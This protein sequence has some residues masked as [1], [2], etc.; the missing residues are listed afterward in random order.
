MS[1]HAA[2]DMR[3]IFFGTPEF[4]VA[5]LA[6]MVEAG[7]AP[8]LVITR[9]A[10]PVGRGHKVRQTPVADWA[11]NNGLEVRRPEKVNRVSFRRD[12]ASLAP[13][14]AVVVAYGLIFGRRLLDLP[15]F[16]CVNVHASLLPRHRGAAPIQAA[17][18]AGDAVTGVTTMRM[19][20]GLDTGPILLQKEVAVAATE[21]GPEL[22]RRLAR[23]GAEL[24]V[25]TLRGFESGE[26]IA[27]QQQEDLASYAPQLTKADGIVDWHRTAEEIYNRLRAFTPWPGQSS[28][29]RGKRIKLLWGRPL[30]GRAKAEPGEVLG[31]LEDLLGVACGE[32]TILGLERVQLAGRKPVAGKDFMNGE[33]LRPGERFRSSLSWHPGAS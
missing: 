23:H 27:R 15:R 14:V 12:L 25:A 29:I 13:D 31:L 20:E 18:A 4:S 26:L 21:T 19:G 6:A 33:R 2:A 7:Y 3:T 9:P 24:L 5:T 17:L 1:N 30:K 11:A 8:Q 32:G 10:R 28:E 16:G 22:S